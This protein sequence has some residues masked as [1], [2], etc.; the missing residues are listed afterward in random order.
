MMIGTSNL[1]YG[2]EEHINSFEDFMEFAKSLVPQ[3]FR[4]NDVLVNNQAYFNAMTLRKLNSVSWE[5]KKE[6]I[7]TVMKNITVSGYTDV[8]IEIEAIYDY[9][10]MNRVN[11]YWRKFN[12]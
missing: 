8:V 6:L 1:S 9:V 4:H 3:E 5:A 7:E 2:L 10:D 11:K 12:G